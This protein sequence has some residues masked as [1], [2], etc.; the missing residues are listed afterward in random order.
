MNK[1]LVAIPIILFALLAVIMFAPREQARE[2]YIGPLTT[3][4]NN[5]AQ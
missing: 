1:Q 3:V 4:S 5:I 2:R